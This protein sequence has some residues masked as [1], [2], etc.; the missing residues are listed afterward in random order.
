[1]MTVFS[2]MASSTS[3]IHVS[4]S[5][6]FLPLF[7]DRSLAHNVFNCA[8]L[9]RWACLQDHKSP[10]SGG[11]QVIVIVKSDTFTSTSDMQQLKNPS[12]HVSEYIMYSFP[13]VIYFYT[14][15]KKKYIKLIC[16]Y[17]TRH[18]SIRE[19]SRRV[20]LILFTKAVSTRPLGHSQGLS[21]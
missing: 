7:L 10:I 9:C 12:L 2:V 1:M 19:K 5:L 16:I 15:K 4:P 18:W 6:F 13:E 20:N 21:N 3:I 17:A 8:G 14:C 11:N